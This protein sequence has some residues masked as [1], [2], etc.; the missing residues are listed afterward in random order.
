MG[1]GN[2]AATGGSEK[3]RKVHT[4]DGQGREDAGERASEQRDCDGEE[5]DAHVERGFIEARDIAR[6]EEREDAQEEV[7]EGSADDSGGEADQQS[8]RDELANDATT[9]GA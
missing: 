5:Q 4:R 7:R 1:A 9:A 3:A 8:L 2:A 6:T